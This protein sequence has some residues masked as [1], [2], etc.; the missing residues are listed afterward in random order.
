MMG[1]MSPVEEPPPPRI[2][3]G[4]PAAPGTATFNGPPLLIVLQ[5][6]G[7]DDGLNAVVPYGNGLYYQLRPNL[8]IAAD[9]VIQLDGQTG[10]HPNL[11][12]FKALWDQ[13]KL[14]IIQGVGY[15]DP[16]RS[17]FRSMD[18]WHTG[19][20]DAS[21]DSGWLGSFMAQAQRADQ[22]PFQSVAIG[23]S[24]PRALQHEHASA[25]ALQ[26]INTF[27]FQTD[28]RLPG[29]RDG[30]VQAFNDLHTRASR[31]H[32]ISAV[33][34]SSWL[35][36][37][38]GVS[39]LRSVGETYRPA[40]QYGNSPFGRALQQV[41]GIA[42]TDLGTRVLYVS[43]GGF[44]THANQRNAHAGLLGQVADGLWALQQDLERSGQADRTM[45]MAFSEFGRRVSENGSGGTDHGA[46]GPVFV[47][48]NRVRGGLY[49]DHPRLNDL[50]EGNLKHTVDFRQVYA[51]I[52]ED[53]LHAS[54]PSILGHSFSRLGIV[55]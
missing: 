29:S 33:I 44:D 27:N 48:G 36:T 52:L 51:T 30:L 42:A 16:S 8:A 32:P 13:Q 43:I 7:G 12:G 3:P 49:G 31:A 55:A 11:Q 23:N 14:A 1:G 41:A 38:G 28:R 47:I 25:S 40:G 53:W 19:S 37:A 4:T 6:S 35:A 45:I 46:A 2:L 21:A 18:I 50:V 22:G 24:V 17:H 15:P 26:D 9:Q 39:Q 34:S 5:L 54:A 10:L 20:L